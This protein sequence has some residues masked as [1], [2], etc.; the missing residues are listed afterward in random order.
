VGSIPLEDDSLFLKEVTMEKRILIIPIFLILSA[1]SGA[2]A[3][4]DSY[5]LIANT[6]VPT[7]SVDRKFL[8]DTFFKKITHWPEDGVIQPVDQKP[9]S[10]VRR[11]FSEDVLGKSVMGVKNY[12]QQLIFSGADVPPPELGNDDEV[13][14]FVSKT[15]GAIGYI[16][17][18]AASL[19]AGIKAVS[20]K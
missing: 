10:T 3:R 7:D 5:Q 11:K 6:K 1:L 16:S 8:A 14:R 18:A 17:S 2:R 13:I 19:P 9:E 4:G 15:P 12:W 20:I